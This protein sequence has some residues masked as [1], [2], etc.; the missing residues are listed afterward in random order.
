MTGFTQG[1]DLIFFAGAHA[2]GLTPTQNLVSA[3]STTVNGT[4]ST[5]LTF[6][7]GTQMTVVGF[8]PGQ[9]NNTFFK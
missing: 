4:A 5:I 6:P 8:T 9:I 7:D 3:N 1:Q 2:G